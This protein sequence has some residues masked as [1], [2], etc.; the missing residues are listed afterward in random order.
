MFPITDGVS[1]SVDSVLCILS[2]AKEL[3]FSSIILFAAPSSNPLHVLIF[4]FTSGFIS[5]LQTA[6]SFLCFGGSNI[7]VGLMLGFFF[8]FLLFSSLIGVFLFVLLVG[9]ANLCIWIPFDFAFCQDPEVRAHE[10]E[11]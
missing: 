7:G 4:P 8:F 11:N 1:C 3:I 6:V 5:L 10:L 9:S 2:S